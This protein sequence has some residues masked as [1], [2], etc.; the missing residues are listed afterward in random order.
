MWSET[1]CPSLGGRTLVALKGC[2]CCAARLLLD[3][4]ASPMLC[5]R[6]SEPLIGSACY[7]SIAERDLFVVW[8][9]T[10]AHKCRQT[11]P[12]FPQHHTLAQLPPRHAQF[13]KRVHTA[14]SCGD[15]IMWEAIINLDFDQELLT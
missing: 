11:Q 8:W 5:C 7:F 14:H 15:T 3:C 12:L 2:S 9:H 13:T 1:F 6:P 4:T 10:Q